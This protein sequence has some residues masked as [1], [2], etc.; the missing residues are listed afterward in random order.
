MLGAGFSVYRASDFDRQPAF[1]AAFDALCDA[2]WRAAGVW[3]WRAF[4]TAD[5][6]HPMVVIAQRDEAGALLGVI[7]G[8][9]QPEPV[10]RFDDLFDRPTELSPRWR[11]ELGWP[12]GGYWHFIALTVAPAA[13]GSGAQQALVGAALDWVLDR[14]GVAQVRTLSPAQGLPEAAA[15]VASLPAYAGASEHV[16]TLRA[17]AGLCDE[18]GRPWLPILRVH[19]SNGADLEAVLFDS[20]A[21]EVRSGAVTLRFAYQRSAEARAEQLARL[22]AWTAARAAVIAAGEATAVTTSRGAAWFVEPTGALA[23][24]WSGLR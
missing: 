21:D 15:L 20:R 18:K 5:G 13:R 22:Q 10:G 19:P 7:V 14:G 8:V 24:P 12:I 4:L 2:D 3:R 6:P 9:W 1:A 17:I 23:P 16:Q 11:D